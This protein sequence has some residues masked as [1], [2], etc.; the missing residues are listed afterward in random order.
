MVAGHWPGSGLSCE[1]ALPLPG[2]DWNK[3]NPQ[4][5]ILHSNPSVASTIWSIGASSL[6][7]DSRAVEDSEPGT[8]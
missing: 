6:T 5:N 1:Q 2:S 8:G 4:T 7:R 3:R